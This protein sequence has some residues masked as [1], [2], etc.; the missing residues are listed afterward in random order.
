MLFFLTCSV[1]AQSEP[2]DH[3]IIGLYENP[4]KVYRDQTQRP[5]GLFVELIEAIARDQGW[6]LD[7]H[8]CE[9]SACLDALET[10]AIDLMPDVAA[11]DD[12]RGRFAFHQVPVTQAWSQLYRPAHLDLLTLDDLR[13]L[14]ISVLR[15]SVQQSWFKSRPELGVDLVPVASMLEGFIAI[16]SGDADA[17][18]TNNFFGARFASTYGLAE[19]AITF[20]Q[21]SLHFAAPLTA[22]PDL[23]TTIDSTLLEWKAQRDS[24][25][26]KALERALVPE[27][28]VTMPHWVAPLTIA[29]LLIVGLLVGFSAVLRWRVKVRTHALEHSRQQLEHVLDSSTAVL[30]QACSDTL[31]PFWVSP[32]VSRLFRLAPADVCAEGLWEMQILED[33]RSKRRRVANELIATG[34]VA[35]DYRIVDGA[36]KVRHLRDEMRTL[37]LDDGRTEVIG[38]W[39]DLTSDYEQREQISYLTSHDRLTHLANRTFLREH[40]NTALGHAKVGDRGGM[41][42]LIDLDRFGAINET[43]GMAIGDQLLAALARRIMAKVAPTDLVARSGNDEFCILMGASDSADMNARLCQ[44]LLETIAAPI[45]LDSHQLS[46]TASIGLACFPAHGETASEVMAAAELALQQARKDGGNAWT[47]YQPEMGTVTSERMYLEQDLNKALDEDQF[48][49]FFQPKYALDESRLIGFESLIR[50]QHPQRGLIMPGTFIPFAEQTGQ[51]R[52][53]DLWVLNESCRQLAQWRDAGLDMPR[54]SVNLSASEFRSEALAQTIGAVIDKFTISPDR[55]ELEI[56]ETTLMEAPDQAAT[57]MV[58][59]AK[60][61]VHLSMDDFGTGYS[62]L[63]QLLALPLNQLK[64]DQSL[65]ANIHNS[66]QKQSVLRAIIALARALDMELVA[67]GIET[68]SQLKFLRESG[69]P[70]GQ[71]YLLGRPMSSAQAKRLL[72]KRRPSGM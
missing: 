63:A 62:N 37:A 19:A 53:I 22:A 61:G 18:A 33:D 9:W 23:L 48:L 14:R 20:D 70:L 50:W 68:P 35:I 39:S 46:V 30:Y 43:M 7:Y 4:P 3:L 8:D 45:Q 41:V 29:L 1:A 55:L 67:E 40:L 11:T 71:G 31:K 64:I 59:L 34:Q 66:T 36:G 72:R 54:L 69:C 44:G 17:A 25:F 51:I 15:D 10:G 57:V 47:G 52:K 16:E 13:G 12:R 32:N 2:R 6:T 28:V 26:F 49:L 42:L 60:L 58:D 27:P 56:T 38:T 5:A 24:P 65:L 21:Q